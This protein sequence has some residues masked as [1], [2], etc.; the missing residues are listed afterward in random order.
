MAYLDWPTLWYPDW[1]QVPHPTNYD[2]SDYRAY[3]AGLYLK[4]ILEWLDNSDYAGRVRVLAHS[5]GN[6]VVGEALRLFGDDHKKRVHTYIASQAA[7][8]GHAY[9]ENLPYDTALLIDPSPTTPEVLRYFSCGKGDV[10]DCLPYYATNIFKSDSTFRYYNRNDYALEKWEINND[11]KPNTEYGY[12]GS[13]ASY[14]PYPDGEDSFY[15]SIYTYPGYI[16]SELD[17]KERL[18]RYEIFSFI[19]ESRARALGALFTDPPGFLGFSLFY[20]LEYGD[21]RYDH[22]RQFFSNI[23]DEWGYWEKFMGDCKIAN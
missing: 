14:S 16:E 3:Q 1:Q 12:R 21:T 6:Q 20:D 7:V 8:S 15:K 17:I 13:I 18:E 11:W 19:A 9:A 5:M 10:D 23:I 4:N 2:R 22:S